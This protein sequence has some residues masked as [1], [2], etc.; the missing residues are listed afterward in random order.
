MRKKVLA[1][2]LA[3]TL[4]VSLGTPALAAGPSFTD[5]AVNHWAYPY[6]EKA[7][8]DEWVTGV[9]GGKFDPDG[10]V[11]GAQFITMVVRAFYEKYI[12]KNE[13][14]DTWYGPYQTVAI[15]H[16][17]IHD[18]GLG[19][20][21]YSAMNRPLTR[22]EMAFILS[23]VISDQGGMTPS[24]D[25]IN[26]TM[27][28]IP[29]INTID[30]NFRKGVAIAYYMGLLSGVDDKGTFDGNSNMNRAQAAVVL[31]RLN[32]V[33]TKDSGDTGK[34][35]GTSTN[36]APDTG[37]KDDQGDNTIPPPVPDGEGKIGQF[38]VEP[39][40]ENGYSISYIP[41]TGI[42][43][44]EQGDRMYGF[45]VDSTD[46]VRAVFD[47]V[48]DNYPKSM[49]FFSK[50]DLDAIFSNLRDFMKPYAISHGVLWYNVDYMRAVPRSIGNQYNSSA[51][52]YY[53]YRLDLHYGAAGIIR[54]YNEGIIDEL[55]DKYDSLTSQDDADYTLLLNAMREI[56]S[57]Y[58]ITDSSSDY[59]KVYAIYNYITSNIRYDYYK[60]SLKGADYSNYISS[61]LYPVEVNFTLSNRKGICHD[62]AKLMEALCCIFDIDCYYVTGDVVSSPDKHAWNIVKIDDEYYQVDATWDEGR[63]PEQYRYFLLSDDHMGET[64]TLGEDNIYVLPSCPKDYR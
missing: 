59:D 1:L 21:L 57:Q 20:N 43:T 44:G 33:L 31:C 16:A 19:I 45:T 11:T 9:G 37:G 5:V 18:Q 22:T 26:A 2:V 14:Y 7:A 39:Y 51:G 52:E 38:V 12:D 35:D 42:W 17:L 61:V 63:T 27:S 4:C 58:G 30:K 55:P 34:Q 62:Y 49:T 40:G 28:Q 36:P 10:K 8:E 56:E 53:E 54:M 25:K 46:D 13:E 6:I 64:H 50:Q 15:K 60:A 41:S 32:D 3:L 47:N 29:D 48:M 23:R 24:K